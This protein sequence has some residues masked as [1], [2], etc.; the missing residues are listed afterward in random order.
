MRGILKLI[1]I[2]LGLFCVIL[3]FTG[4]VSFVRYAWFPTANPAEYDHVQV[5]DV[6]GVIYSSTSFVRDLKKHAENK[7]TKAIVLRINS[8]GGLVA[9]S[10]EMFDAIRHVDEKIPV[11][12]SMATV[13]ASGGYYIA[14]GARKIFANPGSMTGSIGVIM[15]FANTQKLYQWAKMDRFSITS[16]KFKDAGSPL[17]NMTP[18][19]KEL[20]Q[21]MVLDIYGQ[22][23]N[24]VKTRRSLDDAS[25]DKVADGRVLTG[26][27]AFKAKLVDGLGGL[28]EAI[29]E[30]KTLA[31]L[32]PNAKVAYPDKPAGALRKLLLGEE[33]DDASSSS[34]LEGF[35][36]AGKALTRPS[37]RVL[38]LSP[39]Q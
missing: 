17:K 27:Q 16:G 25:M 10:Q 39:V 5:V 9:P 22:F 3:I 37:W 8:P 7:R 18:E 23:R 28:E 19:D 1:G 34:L 33:D 20:F 35:S 26:S 13:A 12:A 2:S 30:A 36:A 4:I 29:T 14:V 15:E 6:A 32:P 38:W 11:V 21:S 31:G 24:T